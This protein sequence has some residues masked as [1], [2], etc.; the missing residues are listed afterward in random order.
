MVSTSFDP[1]LAITPTFTPCPSEGLGAGDPAAGWPMAKAP[2][3]SRKKNLVESIK[4]MGVKPSNIII[5]W[6]LTEVNHGKLHHILHGILNHD[7]HIYI[8]T[9]YCEP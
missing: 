8:S 3:T 4:C 6:R 7:L 9:V 5:S 1:A 2:M